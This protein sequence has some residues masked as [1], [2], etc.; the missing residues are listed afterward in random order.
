MSAATPSLKNCP[1]VTYSPRGLPPKY[2]RR[3]LVS[4]PCSERERVVPKRQRH[5]TNL[6]ALLEHSIAST[7]ILNS[8][9]A[10]GRLV[11]VG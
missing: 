3:C 11:P 8:I 6:R 1:A 4:L 5:R 10:L 9:Q 7:L 2:H